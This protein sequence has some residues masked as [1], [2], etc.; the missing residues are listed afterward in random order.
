V[1]VRSSEEHCHTLGG[2]KA[3]ASADARVTP[4]KAALLQL[5]T[6]AVTP[7]KDE[8]VLWKGLATGRAGTRHRWSEQHDGENARS[9]HEYLAKGTALERPSMQ[10]GDQVGHRNI[11]ETRGG[12]GQEVRQD[13][14]Q[15]ID[16]ESRDEHASDGRQT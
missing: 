8:G 13:A 2:I 5:R 1:P 7:G 14:W 4:A 12:H 9:D 3:R 15:M 16:R 11:E 6:P 10:A